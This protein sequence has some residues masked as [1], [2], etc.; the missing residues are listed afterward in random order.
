[1]DAY[2]HLGGIVTAN[3]SSATEIAFRR[4]QA[5]SVLRPLYKPLFS[6]SSIPLTI[7]IHLL[8]SLVLSRFV[9]ASA[10]TDLT[11]AVHRRGWCKHYVGL[12]RALYRRRHKDEHVHSYAVLYRAGATSPLLALATARAVFL[13]SSLCLGASATAPHV[14]CALD[15]QAGPPHGCRCSASTF[16]L[17]QCTAMLHGCSRTCPARSQPCLRLHALTLHGGRPR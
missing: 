3:C 6:S 8:R 10:I 11:S 4:S 1:M 2:R 14:T 16:R 17:W 7:R 13:S 15:A 5:L 9:F 12:W